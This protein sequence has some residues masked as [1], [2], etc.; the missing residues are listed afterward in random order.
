MEGVYY[1]GGKTNT[2]LVSNKLRYFK[3]VTV[4]RKVVHGEFVNIKTTGTPPCS[5]F[6]HSMCYLPV[7]NSIL[8]AGGRNDELCKTQITPLLND[9]HLFLLDQKVWIQVKYSYNSDRMDFIGNHCMSVITDGDSY[10][11]VLLF[12]GIS[13]IVKG[14]VPTSPTNKK[15]SG[16]LK[17]E[18]HLP[19]KPVDMNQVTSFLSNRCFLITL[20]QRSAGKSFFKEDPMKAA[21]SLNPAANIHK[22]DRLNSVMKS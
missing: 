6:G 19:T 2:G 4:D 10:E 17:E 22:N 3:P 5:R 16:S 20:Q 13:N 11:R 7:N 14:G 18:E 21:K 1:F 8:V 12:G 9:L 15:K